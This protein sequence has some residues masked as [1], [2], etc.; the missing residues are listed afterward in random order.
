MTTLLA[1]SKAFAKVIKKVAGQGVHTVSFDF[2][3]MLI[4]SNQDWAEIKVE[5]TKGDKSAEYKDFDKDWNLVYNIL[6]GVPEMPV[7]IEI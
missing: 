2:D 1:S 7:I 4:Y 6:R 3:R 5:I